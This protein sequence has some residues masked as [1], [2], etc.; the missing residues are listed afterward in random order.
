M[1][2]DLAADRAFVERFKKEIATLQR[3]PRHA[4][5][6]RIEGFGYCTQGQTWYLT[7]AYIDG[8]TLERY[9][10]AKGPLTEAQVHRLFAGV[11]DGLA[12]AHAAGIVHRDIKPSNLIFRE[13]DQ[14]LVLVDFGLSVEVEEVG[15]TRI[16]GLSAQFAAPEQHYGEPATQASDVFSLC[17]VIHYAL[18]YDQPEQ[19]RPN[20]FSPSLAPESLREALTRG[21]A[22]NVKDRL[23]DAGQLRQVFRPMAPPAESAI[24]RASTA[25]PKAPALPTLRPTP[26]PEKIV[27]E[28]TAAGAEVGWMRVNQYGKPQFVQGEGKLGD[29]PAFRFRPWRAGVL[30]KLPD[31]GQ[32]LALE[33][34]GTRVTDAGL[35]ELAGLTGLRW[36]DLRGTRVTDAGVDELSKVLPQ[37]HILK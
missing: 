16:S 34:G 27:K 21:L 31:P 4:N 2:P 12:Q 13:S 23:A 15:H 18:H 33:L 3:L 1:H 30:A 29:V 10:A 36:L 20:R 19:R 5:L 32:A 28:W 14:R 37:C 11:I 8:P 17:A 22:I 24:P 9:L 7:M 25:D 26:L 35:K 6:V